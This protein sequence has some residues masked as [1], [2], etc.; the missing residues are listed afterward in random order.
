MLS[1]PSFKIRF[2]FQL[3]LSF[4]LD[5]FYDDLPKTLGKFVNLVCVLYLSLM[6]SSLNSDTNFYYLSVSMVGYLEELF[7]R[8]ICLFS[9]SL[10][11]KFVNLSG[12]IL[13]YM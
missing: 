13:S 4:N 5:L 11:L 7:G 12:N 2:V 3:F 1:F 8:M 10:S 9:L 6:R